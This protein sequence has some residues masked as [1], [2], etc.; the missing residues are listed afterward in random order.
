MGSVP[1]ANPSPLRPWRF[2]RR[3][4][5]LAFLAIAAVGLVVVGVAIVWPSGDDPTVGAGQVRDLEAGVHVRHDNFYVVKLQSGE[6]I[7]LSRQDPHRGCVIAFRPEYEFN[8][9]TGW[10]LDPCGGSAY[11]VA[12]ALF[13]GP[14]SRDMDRF[15]VQIRGGGSI[16]VDTSRRLCAPDYTASSCP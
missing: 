5:P 7:A 13:F 16:A 1:T 3:V 2:S 4:I 11:D 9:V 8:G 12:G 6:V 10:F 14:S 15:D